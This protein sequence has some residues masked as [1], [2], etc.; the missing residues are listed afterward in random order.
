MKHVFCRFRKNRRGQTLV[1]YG[2]IIALVSVV[3]IAVL[4]SL[5]TKVKG[6]YTGIYSAIASAAAS[7]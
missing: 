5:G 2:M 6:T 4:I 3:A 1:E 7:H